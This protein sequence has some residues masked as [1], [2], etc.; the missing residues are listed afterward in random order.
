MKL[1]YDNS[2]DSFICEHEETMCSRLQKIVAPYKE[3]FSRYGV[4]LSDTIFWTDQRATSSERLPF[5]EGYS[6]FFSVEIERN[7][8]VV[9]YDEAEGFSLVTEV[10]ITTMWRASRYEMIS[11]NDDSSELVEEICEFLRI[12][13]LLNCKINM[14]ASGWMEMESEWTKKA[15]WSYS[16]QNRTQI[17]LRHFSCENPEAYRKLMLF[18]NLVAQGKAIYVDGIGVTESLFKASNIMAAITDEN[19]PEW[20]VL[21]LKTIGPESVDRSIFC[22]EN[23]SFYI[24]DKCVELDTFLKVGRGQARSYLEK[25]TLTAAVSIG[26]EMATLLE[27]KASEIKEV[28]EFLSGWKE[29][30]YKVKKYRNRIF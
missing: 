13:R 15:I 26:K 19:Y 5:C 3:M 28:E 2:C 16:E 25:S 22:L 12:I 11:L 17:V 24:F 10:C 20:K 23:I 21:A 7:G 30:G 14:R 1:K 6:C 29:L 27:V 9:C 4:K 18:L 8:E